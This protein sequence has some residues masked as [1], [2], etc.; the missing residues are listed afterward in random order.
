MQILQIDFFLKKMT[1]AKGSTISTG[2]V[3][4]C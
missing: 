3:L 4:G 2:E 1:A